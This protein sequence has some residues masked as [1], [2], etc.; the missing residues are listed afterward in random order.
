MRSWRELVACTDDT[1]ARGHYGRGANAPASCWVEVNMLQQ[2][3]PATG[4][5]GRQGF[6]PQQDPA[7]SYDTETLHAMSGEPDVSGLP[8]GGGLSGGGGADIPPEAFKPKRTN[9]VMILVALAVVALGGFLLWFGLAQ[10][11]K[12]MTTEERMDVQKNIFVL[13]QK[14]Q[15]PEWRKWAGDKKADENLR[16]EALTQLALLDDDAGVKLCTDALAERS[17]KLRG[18]CAQVLAH[19]DS[20]RADGAKPA[21]LKALKD[22]D[23][24]DRRQIVWALVELGEASVFN[25]AMDAYRSGEIVTVLRLDGGRAFD[26]LKV[27]GLVSLDEL[28]KMATDESS[29]IR[30]LVA[31][32]L[33]EDAKPKW[34]DVLTALVKDKEVVVAAE[35]AT[36]LGKIGNEKARKPLL[37]ALNK[38]D[39]E[40]RL[41]FL[42]ALRDGVGGEGLVLALDTVQKD[43]EQREW[44]Q[45]KQLFDMIHTL[46]DP[47]GGD[48]L[49]NWVETNKPF[50][51]WETEV[52]I[53]LAEIG[54]V[55]GA[56]YLGARMGVENKDIYV[57]ANF[58]QADAGG[59]LTRSDK[60]RVVAARM[61]ADLA[62]VHPEQREALL[63]D[64]EEPVL[65]WMTNRLQPHANGLR[66]LAAANSPKALDKMREWAFPKDPLP[67]EGA[68]PPFPSN[69]ET[70]QSGLR[71]I[72]WMR[73]KASRSKLIDQFDRKEEAKMD[74]TQGGLQGA[75]LAMLG[76]ALRAVS[77]GAAEGLAQWGKQPDS[78]AADKM[79]EFIEDKTWHEEARQAACASLGWI[80]DE[81]ILAKVVEQVGKYAA[82]DDP[83]DQFIGAC[84][85]ITLT[86]KPIPGSI[87]MMVDLLRPE[88]EIGVRVALGRAIGVTG[89]KDAPEAEAKLFKLLDNPELRNPAALAL[90]LGGSKDTASRTVA[91]YATLDPADAEL[92]IGALKE[93]YF[94]AFGYWSDADLD[95]GNIYRW[96]ENANAISRVKIGD[97]PQ[98]WARERLEA[99]FDNLLYDNGPHSETRVVLRYRLVQAAKT[100]DSATK[101]GAIRT[102]QFMKEKGSLMALRNADGETGKL[103]RRAFH[104]LMNPRLALPEDLSDLQEQQND[105]K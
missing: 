1:L 7:N 48:A 21:L 95:R 87:G 25:S 76:M 105:K 30:Q 19:Y 43:T 73:D 72:G 50:K 97:A 35:A 98:L 32:L 10:D 62:I 38:A 66:F 51:H 46:A 39:K 31:T 29:A 82:S 81:K 52:G 26:P 15:L 54:D 60:P 22:S 49:V 17:H 14:E 93:I 64:A 63:A 85:A 88:L 100:G 74:I 90:I 33:S 91:Y 96:V 94:F 45:T 11:A 58:W 83:K 75:G 65:S 67:A 89:L 86:R 42:Q 12:K 4:P 78:R 104:E 59:H 101:V 47:R 61:L 44:F 103:A 34:T 68:Q 55:R 92:A 80:G 36:G 3:T 18:T 16:Q 9:P 24:S 99:Q 102:L 70:A 23:V 71:Y 56:K 77:L 53:A 69:F 6:V 79:M 27:T 57:K 41:K 8:G 2:Q 20:P 13:P 28:A 40:T 37:D 84:Y 5:R